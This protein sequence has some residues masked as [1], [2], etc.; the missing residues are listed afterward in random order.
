MET[1]TTE[2]K[3]CLLN[4]L[5]YAGLVLTLLLPDV[6]AALEAEDGRT[7]PERYKS[8]FDQW[9]A[10][11]YSSRILRAEQLYYLR[12]G[13]A[14]QGKFEHP[15]MKYNRIFFT[16]RPDGM[17]FHC[18]VLNNALN[19]DIPLFCKDMVDGVE[20]WYATKQNDPDRA[21][22]LRQLG[23][24]L[25]EWFTGLSP[26]RSCCGLEQLIVLYGRGAHGSSIGGSDCQGK[27]VRRSFSKRSV[28]G[29]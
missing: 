19:L 10:P 24:L 17:F 26:R 5:W 3:N 2:I 1:L 4:K 23:A 20:N 29:R 6:C 22:E 11:K 12:C 9:V 13:V 27:T 7:T 21:K 18:N 16:L 14:H 8:W 28:L 15:A 25:P